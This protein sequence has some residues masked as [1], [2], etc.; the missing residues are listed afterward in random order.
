M[1]ALSKLFNVPL[2]VISLIVLVTCSSMRCTVCSVVLGHFLSMIGDGSCW[3]SCLLELLWIADSKSD[4][5]L[6]C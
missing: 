1:P 4:R 2:L 5:R 6:R 3:N